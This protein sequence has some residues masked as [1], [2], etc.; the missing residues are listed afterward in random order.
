MSSREQ[1]VR[2]IGAMTQ[3]FVDVVDSLKD[4]VT[5]GS[6]QRLT[7]EECYNLLK[8]VHEVCTL[9]VA[10]CGRDMQLPQ[11]AV[12]KATCATFVQSNTL[13]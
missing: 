9:I 11:E 2:A 13:Q 7:D 6:Q 12:R 3:R 1:R 4:P 10:H 5:N 8:N